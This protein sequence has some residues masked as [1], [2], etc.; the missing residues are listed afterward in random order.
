VST[1]DARSRIRPFYYKTWHGVT[2]LAWRIGMSPAPVAFLQHVQVKNLSPIH[3][4]K[5][6]RQPE[7]ER[8]I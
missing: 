5:E 6:L 4:R 1:T 3:A 7:F 8:Q 2:A